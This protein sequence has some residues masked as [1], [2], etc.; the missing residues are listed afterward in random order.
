MHHQQPEH[1]DPAAGAPDP[2]SNGYAPNAE[3][4]RRGEAAPEWATPRSG[5]L[6]RA[7]GSVLSHRWVVLIC[8]IAGIGG[9]IAVTLNEG[10]QYTATAEVQLLNPPQAGAA[11]PQP[12]DRAAATGRQLLELPAVAQ[13]AARRLGGGTTAGYVQDHI[14]VGSPG[15]GDVVPVKGQAGSSRRAQQLANAYAD[16][17]IAVRRR[18]D[19]AQAAAALDTAR[20][21]LAALPPAD[22]NGPA[23]AALRARVAQLRA[24]SASPAPAASVVQPATAPSSSH[25]QHLVRNLAIGLGA[26]IIVGFLL[27]WL[28]DRFDRRLKTVEQVEQIYELPVLARIPRSR[29]YGKR[30]RR[31]Q[32]DALSTTLGFSEE[33]ESFRALRANLRYFNVDR[34]IRSVLVVSPQSGDGKST[35]ARHLAITMA[36][37]GDSVVLVDADLRKPDEAGRGYEDGLSLVIAGFE[38]D[39]ALIEV[40]ITFDAVTEQSRMLVELPSGPLPPNPSELLESARMRWLIHELEARY[41]VVIIDSP[42]LMTVSDAL[43]LVPEASGVLVVSALDRTTRNSALDLKKQIALLHGRPLGVV[44]NF[45]AGQKSEYYYRYDR[46]ASGA[47]S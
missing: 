28:L 21:E 34:P 16:S 47:R 2:G 18:T 22:Q 44:A 19:A 36:S 9:A 5:P 40:P 37:M 29:S 23:G 31:G 6:D 11:T 1:G 8:L 10:S 39:Q 17:Y 42:A 35:I 43:S 32:A 30:G 46:S 7:F 12:P 26:A 41:D 3:V 13:A 27:A 24:A 14:D 38:L 45:W 20:A 4:A 33:A 15:K 25:A